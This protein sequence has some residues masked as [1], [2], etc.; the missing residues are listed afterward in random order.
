MT[1]EVLADIA[2][3]VLMLLTITLV[4]AVAWLCV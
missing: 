2:S 1:R 4:G 3:F